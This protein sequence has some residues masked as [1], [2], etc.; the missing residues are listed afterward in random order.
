MCIQS[1]SACF[2][3]IVACATSGG[4]GCADYRWAMDDKTY[5]LHYRDDEDVDVPRQVKQATDARF[6]KGKVGTYGGGG[7]Q[8]SPKT[9]G[10][11]LGVF[12][13]PTSWMEWRGGLACLGGTEEQ[14]FFGGVNIGARVQTS[15]RLAPFV[16]TGVFCG[17][18][19]VIVDATTDGVDNDNDAIIDEFGETEKDINNVLLAV[20]PEVGLHWWVDSRWRVTGSAGYYVTTEGREH[21]F[22]L[23]SFGISMLTTPRIAKHIILP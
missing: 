16:G 9:A 1:K 7:W 6:V 15:S 19:K 2:F 21:D 23:Y 10:G 4:L 11:E 5:N 14:D 8:D 17:Y 12:G 13:Y 20:Y 22:W 3:F 18:S